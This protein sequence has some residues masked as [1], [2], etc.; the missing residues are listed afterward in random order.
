MRRKLSILRSRA[1]LSSF[2]RT[3]FFECSL[4]AFVVR[5]LQRNRCLESFSTQQFARIFGFIAAQLAKL[6]QQ[7][8]QCLTPLPR[9]PRAH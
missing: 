7:F 1:H 8:C 3:G 4:I 5:Q 6:I 9:V 2:S